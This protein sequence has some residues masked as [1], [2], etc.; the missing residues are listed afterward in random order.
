MSNVQLRQYYQKIQNYET[1]LVAKDKELA[2]LREQ[3]QRLAEER[4][5]LS[6]LSD[7]L[8]SETQNLSSTVSEVKEN[9]QRLTQAAAV[10]KAENIGV[11]AYN[12]REKQ[13]SR[14]AF[15]AS[16]IDKLS[17]DFSLG[18]NEIA[19]A[20]NRMIYMRLVEP[21]GTVVKGAEGGNF[22]AEGQNLSFTNRKSVVYANTR[23]PVTIA[24]ERPDDYKF[25]VGS[26]KVELY[27]DGKLIGFKVF[28]I[29]K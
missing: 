4:D 17:I 3:N 26:H 8:S 28:D 16:R 10:L 27:A 14:N 6:S 24:F 12:Q 15:R 20:G 22:E 5:Q 25:K 13:E 1:A 11:R 9:N 19:A 21:A 18:E 29:A 2:E 7:S 23:T